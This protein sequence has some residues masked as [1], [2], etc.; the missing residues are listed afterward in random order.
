MPSCTR[1][2]WNAGLLAFARVKASARVK[3]TFV[4]AACAPEICGAGVF[5]SPACVAGST[6]IGPD[7]TCA[8]EP[9]PANN[10]IAMQSRGSWQLR[11]TAFQFTESQTEP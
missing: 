11:Y 1:A 7:V 2:A 10:Q 5:A 8:A 6:C 3:L 9:K 4:F